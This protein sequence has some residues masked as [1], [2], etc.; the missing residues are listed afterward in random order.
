MSVSGRTGE[1][2]YTDEELIKA[3]QNNNAL[4]YA[5]SRGYHLQKIGNEYHLKEHDSM[6][7]TLDGKWHW[8]SKDL[9]GHALD[10]IQ[11]YENCDYKEAIC[12]LAGT[13]NM[14]APVGPVKDIPLA[15][16]EKKEFVL[17]E[18]ADNFKIIFAYLIKERGIDEGLVKHLVVERKLYQSKAYNNVVM[19]GFDDHNTARYASLRSTNSYKKIFKIDV[20]G[21]DKSY[22]FIIDSKTSSN[23]V[24]VFE[25]PIEAMS[26][27]TLCKETGSSFTQDYMISKGGSATFVPL[28]RFLNDHPEVKNIILC[29]NNDSKEFGHI[30]NAGLNATENLSKRY[31][32]K[33]NIG[34]HIPHL[35]DW[36]DVL[37]NYRHNLES[38][39][40]E[41][42]AKMQ[43]L[44]RAKAI[45]KPRKM[46]MER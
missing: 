30:I 23:T 9:H 10:F 42:T 12:L 34:T 41:L 40:S 21:S 4:K 13:L 20:P 26:Y 2:Y 11:A 35:N 46:S 17:P 6:V 29:L 19:V 22:P 31:Q 8:N 25:S 27:W 16:A 39:M 28:D 14:P 5:L 7:F 45:F 44:D 15:P 38:K 37:K 36:N 43:G 3:K 1:I 24:R 18:R 33:Y 32:D